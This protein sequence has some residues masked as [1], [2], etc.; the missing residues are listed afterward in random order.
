MYMY[1]MRGRS[2]FSLRTRHARVDV[3]NPNGETPLHWA[4]SLGHVNAVRLLLQHGADPLLAEEVG[5]QTPLHAACGARAQPAAVLA[6]LIQRCELM[7][8]SGQPQRCNVLDRKRNSVLHTCTRQ[9]PHAAKSFPMLLEHGA[10]PNLQNAQA[11][12][13]FSA[14]SMFFSAHSTRILR[15]F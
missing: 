2:L 11:R 10:N 5:G 12:R 15:A 3:R 13:S 1:R 4:A 6:L 14:H 7:G 8:W 9:A